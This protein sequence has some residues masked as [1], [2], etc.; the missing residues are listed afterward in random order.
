M[1][2]LKIYSVSDDYISYL[3]SI[4]PRVYSNK[5]DT[6][7]HTRKYLG[8]VLE[9]NGFSYFIPMSSPKNSDYV[10]NEDKKTIRKSIIPI[11]RM[12]TKN[13]DGETELIGTLRISHMIP[14]PSSEL[15]LYDIENETDSEYRELVID[16]LRYINRYE[17]KIVS[18]SHIMYKQKLSSYKAGYVDSALNYSS[19]ER[20][21]IEYIKE[22]NKK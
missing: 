18:N 8:V 5:E 19:V 11:I 15:Q 3:R 10:L 13:P 22:K 7:T 1:D 17:K 16:E 2:S 9:I 12:T 21:C 4:E 20:Y 6:R 14:V